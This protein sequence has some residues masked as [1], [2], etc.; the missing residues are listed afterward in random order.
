MKLQEIK[1]KAKELGI[2]VAKMKKEQLIKSIQLAE[3]NA[4]CF[5]Q[6]DSKCP[7][8]NCSWWDDCIKEYES[9]RK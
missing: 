9:F 6:N 8:K 7:W 5:G 2:H 4:V 1:D 3:G